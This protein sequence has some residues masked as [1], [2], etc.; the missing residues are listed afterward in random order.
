MHISLNLYV[1]VMI[2]TTMSR[3]GLSLNPQEI[4]DMSLNFIDGSYEVIA[5]TTPSLSFSHH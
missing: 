4:Q 5:I 2:A 1:D 3:F